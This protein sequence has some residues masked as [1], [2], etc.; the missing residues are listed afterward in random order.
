MTLIQDKKEPAYYGETVTVQDAEKVLLRW[1][2]SDGQYRVIFG[3]L[4]ALDVSAEELTDLEKVSID[5][6]GKMPGAIEQAAPRTA[7]EPTANDHYNRGDAHYFDGD[8]DQAFLELT[9][10]IEKDP[11]LVRAYVTRGQAYNDKNEFDLAI[12]DFSR[13]IELKPADP[14]AYRYRGMAYG[15]KGQYD[16]AL[17]DYSKAIEIDPTV[18]DAYSGRARAYYYKGQYDK[19]WKD[20]YKAQALGQQVDSKLLEKL[21]KASGRDG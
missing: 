16:L 18:A 20:V 4:S 21:R 10:A 15:N 19:A 13:I 5:G 7:D 14:H 9:K 11:T 8:Y 3:D 17:A 2:V 6:G 1:K 12:A